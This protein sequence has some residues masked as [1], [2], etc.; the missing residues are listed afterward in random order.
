MT[1]WEDLLGP[2]I[3]NPPQKS[4]WDNLFG[5]ADSLPIP[6]TTPQLPSAPKWADVIESAKVRADVADTAGEFIVGGAAKFD[7][8]L[9]GMFNQ[10]DY[11]QTTLGDAIN[12]ILVGKDVANGIKDIRNKYG[13]DLTPR[14]GGDASINTIRPFKA[15][16]SA[17]DWAYKDAKELPNTMMGDIVGG[18]GAIGPEILAATVAPEIKTGQIFAKYGMPILSKFGTVMGTE[19]AI[20]GAQSVETGTTMQKLTTPFIGAAEQ[21]ITGQ[22]YDMMGAMSSKLGSKLANKFIPEIKTKADFHSNMLIHSLGTTST[23]ALAFGGYGTLNEFLE[24]GKS[25]WRTFGT[26]VGMGLGLGSREIGKTL[27]AKGIN[28][29]IAADMNT[30]KRAAESD[31]SSDEMISYS[32]DKVKA[33]ESRAS[34]NS[35]GDMTSAILSNNTAMLKSVLEEIKENPQDVVKS[36]EESTL[37]KEIKDHV[38]EKVNQVVV[39]TDPTAVAS[40]PITDRIADIDAQ[41]DLIKKNSNLAPVLQEIKIKSLAAKREGLVNKVIKIVE[42]T[43]PEI[44][45][46]VKQENLKQARIIENKAAQIFPQFQAEGEAL[47]NELGGRFESRLKN[48]ESISDKA[49]REGISSTDVKDIMGGAIIVDKMG[50]LRTVSRRLKKEGYSISNKRLSDKDT[51]R[52]GVVATK[53]EDGISKEIQIHTE[54]TWEVQKKAEAIR[55][56]YRKEGIPSVD[57]VDIKTNPTKYKAED[58]IKSHAEMGSSVFSIGGE[59][60]A[61]KKGK[62]S[63]SLFPERAETISKTAKSEEQITMEEPK[64]PEGFVPDVQQRKS[65]KDKVSIEDTEG[66][67]MSSIT[68]RTVKVNGD[69]YWSIQQA[70]TATG[71]EGK[72]YATNL[73]KYAMQNLPEGYKGII[74]PASTRQ[75]KVQIPKIHEK[76]A[77]IFDAQTTEN[78]D[79]IF[80]PKTEELTPEE[81]KAFIEKNKDILEGNEDILS[82]STHKK[83]SGEHILNITAI[84]TKERAIELGKRYNKESIFDL[85]TMKEVPTGGTGEDIDIKPRPISIEDR[86]KELRI[87]PRSMYE[88][89][90]AESRR[91]YEEGYAGLEDVDLEGSP[92]ITA[93]KKKMKELGIPIAQQKELNKAWTETKNKIFADIKAKSSLTPSKRFYRG[94]PPSEMPK[95]ATAEDVIK[96]EK[97]EL[98]NKDIQVEP[99]IDLKKIDA[100]NISWLSDTKEYA[101][102]FG[103]VT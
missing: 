91:L 72:G 26:G 65:G 82:I 61:G 83:S 57:V 66:N 48:V 49:D 41:I 25:S 60:L 56:K 14:S 78:G 28:T 59:N 86:I 68:F 6:K 62:A 74:S 54:K 40:K 24:S 70:V 21:Y 85:E 97:D 32:Q 63:I 101:Q 16:S 10:L 84:P 33:V 80:R 100:K 9:A 7:Q 102:S 73:Y 67:E 76:L 79:I 92:A 77:K 2:K 23:S 46:A 53:V 58:Q 34:K 3:D 15:I 1:N 71:S 19:G 89:A 39:D 12:T 103:N 45:D 52:R 50:D 93:Q 31:I 13:V 98:G 18:I 94:G 64:F 29:F 90:M 51:G 5:V 55:D 37:P 75:N 81:I 96:Y 8:A 38:I 43:K 36:I 11:I 20:S 17:I 87:T 99:D 30:I 88:E 69:K 4:K 47:A 95:N 35:E 27:W 44:P 22:V 42:E